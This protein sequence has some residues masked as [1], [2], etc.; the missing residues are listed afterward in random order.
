MSDVE[1]EDNNPIPSFLSEEGFEDSS[2]TYPKQEYKNQPSTN[3]RARGQFVIETYNSGT[4]VAR[5][6]SS[7]NSYSL[8]LIGKSQSKPKPQYP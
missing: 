7:D 1:N 4:R 8:R 5:K 3:L 6:K 2:G